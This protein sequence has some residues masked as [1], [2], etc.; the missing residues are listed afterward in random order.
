VIKARAEAPAFFLAPLEETDVGRTERGKAGEKVECQFCGM[1]A[2]RV[3]DSGGYSAGLAAL[4]EPEN[5]ARHFL[6]ADADVAIMVE[7]ILIGT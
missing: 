3:C 7:A 1:S 6:V 5:A 2:F 4:A